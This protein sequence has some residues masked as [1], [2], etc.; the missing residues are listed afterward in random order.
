T[1][2]WGIIVTADRFLINGYY[3]NVI[4]NDS[5]RVSNG[6]RKIYK[7]TPVMLGLNH[8]YYINRN[9]SIWGEIAVGANYRS[10]S[11]RYMYIEILSDN[12]QEETKWSY[13]DDYKY[14]YVYKEEFEKA[15]SFAFQISSGIKFYNCS[16]GL[17]Y[18]NLGWAPIKGQYS[19]YYYPST[20]GVQYYNNKENIV[21]N[22]PLKY[23]LLKLSMFV[24]R[25]GYHF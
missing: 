24:L 5:Y 21:V 13:D 6:G 12:A 2:G 16:L 10:I 9:V 17:H 25:L 4:P 7:N 3:T 14:D 18:Y 11:D 19:I 1:Y 22:N 15:L 8:D 23:P 20:D